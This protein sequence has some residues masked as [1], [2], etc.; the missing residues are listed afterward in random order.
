MLE[1]PDVAFCEPLTVQEGDVPTQLLNVKAIRLLLVDP[2]VPPRLALQRSQNM[3]VKLTN[4]PY[5]GHKKQSPCGAT[6]VINLHVGFAAPDDELTIDVEA[7]RNAAG[8]S[9]VAFLP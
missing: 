6:I 7:C 2:N 5:S 1:G 4:E 3:H 9:G 8:T